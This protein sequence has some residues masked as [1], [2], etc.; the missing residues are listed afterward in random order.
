M[1]NYDNQNYR[2]RK[3]MKNDQNKELGGFIKM[4]K[5]GKKSKN[6]QMDLTVNEALILQ[7]VF[8]DGEEEVE[9]LVYQT[10]MPK[11]MTLN[12]LSDLK[13]K[14]LLIVMQQAYGKI[15]VSI[16]GRGKKLIQT[17]WPEAILS[18]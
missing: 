13:S 8:E 11:R 9:N 2:N 6:K 10:G 1:R 5:I 7:Q 12:I 18:Y 3:K 15:L 4:K 17:M 16:T 14:G